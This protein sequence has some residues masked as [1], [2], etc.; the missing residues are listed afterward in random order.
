MYLLAG[1]QLCAPEEGEGQEGLHPLGSRAR[2][3]ARDSAS[4][5]HTRSATVR[6]IIKQKTKVPV[7]RPELKYQNFRTVLSLG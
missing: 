2:N 6:I 3:V 7:L 1:S 4:E 5:L